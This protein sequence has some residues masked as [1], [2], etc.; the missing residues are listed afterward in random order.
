MI[1]AL[2]IF[3]FFVLAALLFAIALFGMTGVW[4]EFL[5]IS[6]RPLQESWEWPVGL[7]VAGF[8]SGF[9]GSILVRIS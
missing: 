9:F 2:W 4:D 1:K 7:I 8:A 5:F 6:L 3:G